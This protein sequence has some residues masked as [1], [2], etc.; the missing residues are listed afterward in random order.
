MVIALCGM[1]L[2]EWG[3]AEVAAYDNSSN[4]AKMDMEDSYGLSE[5]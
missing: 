5:E 2:C 1:F 3:K 4:G